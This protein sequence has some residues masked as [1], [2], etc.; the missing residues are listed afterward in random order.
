MGQTLARARKGTSATAG[1]T[2]LAYNIVNESLLNKVM[3][4]VSAYPG[5]HPEESKIKF[6]NPIAWPTGLKGDD[7]SGGAFEQR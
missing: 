5:S 6:K 7:F 1:S 2:K 3:D 4:W